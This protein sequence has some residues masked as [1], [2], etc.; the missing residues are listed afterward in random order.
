[1]CTRELLEDR[2]VDLVFSPWQELP[3]KLN[4]LGLKVE[5]TEDGES[6]IIYN[7]YQVHGMTDVDPPTKAVV[8]AAALSGCFRV[9]FYFPGLMPKVHKRWKQFNRLKT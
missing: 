9:G 6:I 7:A 8:I 1:M 4:R 2:I 5:V 3:E